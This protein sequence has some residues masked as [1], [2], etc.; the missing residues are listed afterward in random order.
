[1]P[2]LMWLLSLVLF[3]CSSVTPP[4]RVDWLEQLESNKQRTDTVPPVACITN[5]RHA[6]ISL[7]VTHESMWYCLELQARRL[8]RKRAEFD[9]KCCTLI[10]LA[11]F[12]QIETVPGFY[13]SFMLFCVNAEFVLLCWV[14]AGMTQS[15]RA[16]IVF[17]VLCGP[18][19][20]EMGWS[21]CSA[22]GCL[23]RLL[24]VVQRNLG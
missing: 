2:L 6:V 12:W 7:P 24:S 5:I 16:A 20:S 14:M 8:W 13:R 19:Y 17:A 22:A 11:L 4:C 3:K 9:V 23:C 21:G 18:R 10:K 1:M 15:H